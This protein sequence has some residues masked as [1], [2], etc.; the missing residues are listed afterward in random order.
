MGDYGQIREFFFQEHWPYNK[1][2]CSK[3]LSHF[4]L[5]YHFYTP[6]KRPKTKDFLKFSGGIEMEHWGND[7]INSFTR[8]F[9]KLS[10]GK[11][12]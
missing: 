11:E 4:M 9:L 3:L 7:L 10:R 1:V 2:I 5:M 12:I 8:P 6:W